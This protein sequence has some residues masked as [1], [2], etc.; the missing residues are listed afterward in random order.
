MAALRRAAAAS[1]RDLDAA[2]LRV[3]VLAPLDLEPIR[4]WLT[5]PSTRLEALANRDG[6][7]VIA[8]RRHGRC[9]AW[10][11]HDGSLVTA[12]ELRSIA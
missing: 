1:D 4:A 7:R 11:H 9:V 2:L 3:G 6:H 12:N 10:V 8:V 5:A